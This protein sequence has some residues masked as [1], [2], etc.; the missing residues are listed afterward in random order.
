MQL[1]KMNT[2]NK[3]REVANNECIATEEEINNS[4]DLELHIVSLAV[5]LAV[6]FLGASFSVLS[7]RVRC[8]HVNP[9]VINVGKFFGSG[10]V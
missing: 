8:L 3:F 2:I 10:Y 9:I 6:S 4:Y 7:S 5:L 1:L